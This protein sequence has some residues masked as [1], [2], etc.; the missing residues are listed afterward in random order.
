MKRNLVMIHLESLNNVIYRMNSDC[1]PNLTR[2]EKQSVSFSKYF[3]TATSTLMV[4]GDIYYGGMEQYEQCDSLDY[5]PKEYPYHSSMLDDLK[6][7]GYKVGAY[8]YPEGSDR[9]SAEKRHIAGFQNEMLLK[10]HYE[11]FL[12]AIEIIV[13]EEPFAVSICNYISNMG[14]N[15]YRDLECEY[16]GFEN[17]K[18]GYQELDKCVGHIFEILERKGVL[19]TTTVLLYG[20]HGDDYWGHG[21]H[22]GLAHAIEP[23]AAL[24]HAPMFIYDNRISPGVSD[25]VISAIDLRDMLVKLLMSNDIVSVWQNRREYAIARTSYA[26]QPIR[27]DSFKKAYSITDGELLLLVSPDGLELYNIEMDPMCTYNFLQQF[28]YDGNII[29]YDTMKKEQCKFHYGIFMNDSQISYLRQKFYYLHK[30]LRSE[31]EKLYLCAG[32]SVEK[33]DE[34]MRFDKIMG[35]NEICT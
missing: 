29:R 31:V 23:Y 19:D 17:W 10:R 25:N 33:M 15:I 11:D 12:D 21:L 7:E 34:E 8:I 6:A 28:L 24:I 5:I 20:D 9:D 13:S 27:Y 16:T 2:I 22:K 18:R 30:R 3:S 4:L 14:L 1:F 35:E 26:A 32:S